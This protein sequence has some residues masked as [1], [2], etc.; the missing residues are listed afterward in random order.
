[1]RN[2]LFQARQLTATVS[3]AL[4]FTINLCILL[5]WYYRARYTAF[6][7]EIEQFAHHRAFF[8]HKTTN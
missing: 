4:V 6:V 5:S 3:P 8:Y 7:Y 1:M 2:T